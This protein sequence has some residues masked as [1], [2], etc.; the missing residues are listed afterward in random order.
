MRLV[1]SLLLS[2]LLSAFAL[3][4]TNCGGAVQNTPAP[5]APIVTP[6]EPPQVIVPVEEV[7]EKAFIWKATSPA[8]PDKVL[9]LLGSVHAANADFYPLD[10]VIE[11]AYE[12]SD[13]LIVELNLAAI[14][15]E[16]MLQVVFSRAVLPKDQSLKSRLSEETWSKLFETL[17]K[18]NVPVESVIR[19]K[20]WF[21][22]LTIVTLRIVENGYSPAYGIDQHFI[23]KDD[24][25]IIELESA[26]YQL[27]LFDEL[28]KELEELLILD[29]MEGS[30]Q[31]GG[32]LTQVMAA[33]RKGDSETLREIMFSS[34]GQQPEFEPLFKR[35]FIDR[36]RTMA[37]R[38]EEL[39]ED[40]TSLFVVVGAGHLVGDDGLVAIFEGKGYCVTQLEKLKR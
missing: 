2:V 3:H 17:D 21:A 25:E 9:Y 40:Y 34:V 13:V 39:L 11:E 15:N 12:A 32:D 19:F 14:P 22:A 30:F 37:S 10:P 24:K 1:K 18:Y 36:N 16:K 4:L 27:A 5:S 6:R 7:A 20:P 8:S 29:A 33:W 38:I 31:S 26:D 28:P 35:I 23:E